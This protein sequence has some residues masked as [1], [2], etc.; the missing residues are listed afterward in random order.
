LQ[1]VKEATDL[2]Y[3]LFFGEKRAIAAIVLHFSDLMDIYNKD[4]KWALAFG[5]LSTH[6]QIRRRSLKLVAER[7]E[8]FK[9]K[10][11]SEIFALHKANIAIDYDAVISVIVKKG[12]LSSYMEIITDGKFNR[13]LSFLIGKN[14][15]T[16]AKNLTE[17]L[18]PTKIKA[19]AS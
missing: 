1:G 15:F 17:R 4:N 11:L 7:R 9:N 19:K 2:V 10:T 18:F 14:Q 16:E 13:K 3:D 12:I 6:S 5:N 8:T